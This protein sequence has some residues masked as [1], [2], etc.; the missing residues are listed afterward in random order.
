MSRKTKH[1]YLNT[2]NTHRSR[3]L[4]SATLLCSSFMCSS[5]STNKLVYPGSRMELPDAACGYPEQA[6]V[7]QAEDGT[8]LRGWFFNRGANTPLVAMYGG[9]GMNDYCAD[10]Q[11]SK[12][13]WSVTGMACRRSWVKPVAVKTLL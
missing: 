9:N 13:L 3:M 7:L 11:K 8:Q 4:L 5:C 12:R 10:N 2:V 1:P 6:I